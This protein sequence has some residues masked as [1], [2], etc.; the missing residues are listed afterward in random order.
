MLYS[1]GLCTAILFQQERYSVLLQHRKPVLTRPWG[2]AIKSPPALY[3]LVSLQTSSRRKA[4]VPKFHRIR[5]WYSLFISLVGVA[6]LR[7]LHFPA[8]ARR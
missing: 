6:F 3:V 4:F 5:I 2:V 1:T 7:A 8:F